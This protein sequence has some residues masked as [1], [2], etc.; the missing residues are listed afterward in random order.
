MAAVVWVVSSRVVIVH[1]H[2][3]HA[4]LGGSL[5][6][7]MLVVLGVVKVLCVVAPMGHKVVCV[8]AQ[9]VAGAV[10]NESYHLAVQ[11]AW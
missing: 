6:I 1:G 9:P 3:V 5:L 4:L 10:V 8:V 2:V 11:E 7:V